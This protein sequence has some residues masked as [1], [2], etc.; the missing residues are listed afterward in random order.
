VAAGKPLLSIETGG[1]GL[2]LALYIPPEQGKKIAPGMEVRIE[3]ATVRK[4]EYGTLTGRVLEVSE[5]PVSRAGMLAVLQNP[6][7]AARFSAQ[8]APYAARVAL[9]ADA[10][11]PSGYAWSAG[12]G[13][14]VRLTSGTTAAAE[15]TVRAQAPVTLVLPLLRQRTGITW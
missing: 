3:P 6:Q 15:V 2:E 8:G 11:T 13:P 5:F 7:L 14:P 1:K 4:E 9:L 10:G 12:R